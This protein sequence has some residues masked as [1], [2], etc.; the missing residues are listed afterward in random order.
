[1]KKRKMSTK[2][3]IHLKAPKSTKAEMTLRRAMDKKGLRYY[4]QY[5]IR[6]VDEDGQRSWSFTVDFLVLPD[7]VVEVKGESHTWSSQQEKDEWR[8]NL[9]RQQGFKVV[10]VTDEEVDKNVEE[11]VRRIEDIKGTS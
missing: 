5:T 4:S 3:A 8:E 11:V 7:I 2:T 6:C 9:L 1:M 10:S